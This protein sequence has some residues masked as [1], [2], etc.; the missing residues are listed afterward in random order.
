MIQYTA[1]QKQKNFHDYLSQNT[2][3]FNFEWE[4]NLI[5]WVWG[6]CEC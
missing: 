1:L 3:I 4:F 2:N 6:V 5:V